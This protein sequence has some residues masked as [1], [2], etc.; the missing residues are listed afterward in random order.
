MGKAVDYLLYWAGDGTAT[1]V[2]HWV[3]TDSL[4]NE[5]CIRDIYADHCN[6]GDI[7]GVG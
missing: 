6:P 1:S 3:F 5:G 7:A 4:A 2:G